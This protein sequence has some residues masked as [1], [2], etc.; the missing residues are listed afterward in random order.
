MLRS[1][2]FEKK[3]KKF[4]W[5]KEFGVLFSRIIGKEKCQGRVCEAPEGNFTS[6]VQDIWS[7]LWDVI[8][9]EPNFSKKGYLPGDNRFW[10]IF[11]RNIEC[12][13]PPGTICKGTK[14]TLTFTVEVIRSF[15]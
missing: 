7:F 9:R 10:A 15:L 11:S 3:R 6:I 14:G 13:K 1:Q 4:Q 5:R 12:G 8:C 2:T